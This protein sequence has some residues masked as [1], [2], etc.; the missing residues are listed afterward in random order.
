MKFKI[1]LPMMLCFL[2]MALFPKADA[3]PNGVPQ[4]F[5]DRFDRAFEYTEAIAQAMPDSLYGFKPNEEVFSFGKQIQHGVKTVVRHT[6][7]YHLKQLSDD[8]DSRYSNDAL[9]KESV[10]EQLRRAHQEVRA[11]L[12]NMEGAKWN[13][14]VEF[15]SGTF[16]TWHFFQILLDHL[17]HHRAMAIVYLRINGI[18]PP[19]RYVGW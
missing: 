4:V 16:P 12:V 5:L 2:N 7:N 19:V 3:Q 8:I 15:F 10:L 11:V 9:D 17:T 18:A 6:E 13:D 1:H 14:E